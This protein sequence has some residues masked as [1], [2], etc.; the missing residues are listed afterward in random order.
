MLLPLSLHYLYILFSTSNICFAPYYFFIAD[1]DVDYVHSL[2]LIK[3]ARSGKLILTF[4]HHQLN[5]QE[6]LDLTRIHML[7]H[8]ISKLQNV[9]L[10]LSILMKKKIQSLSTKQAQLSKLVAVMSTFCAQLHRQSKGKRRKQSPVR[11]I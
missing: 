3:K 10:K 2:S 1:S 9:Q 11:Q 4:K 8:C 6:W 5:S 7:K